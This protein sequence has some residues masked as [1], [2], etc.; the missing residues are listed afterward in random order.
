MRVTGLSYMSISD[1]A[2]E[3]SVAQYDNAKI[4]SKATGGKVSV[5]ELCTKRKQRTPPQPS[6]ATKPKRGP[7]KKRGSSAKAAA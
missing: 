4:I 1:L 5:E 7:R 3:R 2:H 6:A